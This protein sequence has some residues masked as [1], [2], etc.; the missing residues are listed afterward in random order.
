[1]MKKLLV[2]MILGVVMCSLL[3]SGCAQ[4]GETEAE[5][6]RR[7][8]RT[9]RINQEALMGDMDRAALSDKPSKLTPHRIP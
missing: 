2:C 7:H 9:A 4:L 3:V 6:R 1:M 5:G 8:V